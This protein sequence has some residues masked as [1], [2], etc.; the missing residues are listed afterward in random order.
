ML[1]KDSGNMV[2]C[3]I[4]VFIEGNMVFC[5]IGTFI[6]EFL[7][8]YSVGGW[9]R[10]GWCPLY[11]TGAP[12]RFPV[13]FIPGSEPCDLFWPIAMGRNNGCSTMSRD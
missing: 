11:L 13:F 8:D 4:C 1:K 10:K 12:L 2:F 9:D 6:K 3:L 5:M 7:N